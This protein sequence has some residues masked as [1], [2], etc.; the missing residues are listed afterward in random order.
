M[1]MALCHRRARP[2]LLPLPQSAAVPT[3][4][5]PLG[6][7]VAMEPG[8]GWELLAQ[9][10]QSGLPLALRAGRAATRWSHT[11]PID[12]LTLQGRWLL[13]RSGDASFRLDE[14]LLVGAWLQR[15]AGRHG[16]R[17]TLHLALADGSWLDLAD[18][19]APG[20]PETCAWRLLVQSLA[21]LEP[22]DA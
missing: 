15:D 6:G 4:P 21:P 2:A 19:A 1:N 17:H 8:A 11:G 10:A 12:R 14:S 22:G 5:L 20:R 18:A 7:S 9:A 13:L 16:L 3:P